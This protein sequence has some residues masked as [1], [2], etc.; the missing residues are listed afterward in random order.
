[1]SDDENL[2]TIDSVKADNG[3]FVLKGTLEH[4]EFVYLFATRD[5]G[6]NCIFSKILLDNNDITMKGNAQELKCEYSGATLHDEYMDYVKYLLQLPSQKKVQ[7]LY[8]RL[9]EADANGTEQ[10]NA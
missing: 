7:Q 6:E 5:D 10:E 4:P 2:N 8:D 1:M 9:A 3:K